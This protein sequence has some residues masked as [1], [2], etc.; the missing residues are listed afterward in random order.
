MRYTRLLSYSPTLPLSSSS[1][2]LEGRFCHSYYL[3]PVSARSLLANPCALWQ[4]EL[5]TAEEALATADGV[6]T[7]P[8][9]REGRA[10]TCRTNND[11]SAFS[12]NCR[13]YSCYT[14]TC[15]WL[16][17]SFVAVSFRSSRSTCRVLSGR[18]KAEIERRKPATFRKYKKYRRNQR[19]DALLRDD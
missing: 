9:W 5:S 10:H 15:R 18:I 16:V 3:V 8:K 1:S 11:T 4:L 7:G 12:A 2:F 13:G 6:W 19:G 14:P 17:S